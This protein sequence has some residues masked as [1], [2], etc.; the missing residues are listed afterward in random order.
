MVLTHGEGAGAPWEVMMDEDARRKEKVA[1]VLFLIG[2]V[3]TAVGVTVIATETWAGATA[4]AGIWTM[5]WAGLLACS[6]E[7]RR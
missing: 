1:G 6:R 3:A 4:L 2:Y 7:D 5:V